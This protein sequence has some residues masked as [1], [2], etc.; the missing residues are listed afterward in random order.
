MYILVYHVIK[1][2]LLKYNIE[3]DLANKGETVLRSH[4]PR[5]VFRRRVGSL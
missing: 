5:N 1:I 4:G 3:E 2:T